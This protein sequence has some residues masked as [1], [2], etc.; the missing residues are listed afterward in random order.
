MSVSKTL[1]FTLIFLD[2]GLPIRYL[3]FE[4]VVHVKL[5]SLL[6]RIFS[7]GTVVADRDDFRFAFLKA[8]SR[9][10]L[11]WGG[12]FFNLSKNIFIE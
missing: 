1:A 2:G 12:C 4:L 11:F 5:V 3:P 9:F 6:L 7:L 10:E 8:E